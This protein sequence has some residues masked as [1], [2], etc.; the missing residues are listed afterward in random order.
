MPQFHAVLQHAD[1]EARDNVDAGDEYAG[2]RIALSEAGGAVHGAIELRL[3]RQL[4]TALTRRGLVDESGTQIRI[5]G[6]LLSGQSVQG[7][8]RRDFRDTHRAVIDDHVLNRDQYQEDH[9]ADDV[10]AAHHKA[11]EGFDY[12]SGGG[13]AR[14]AIQQDQPRR[15]NVQGQPV[16]RQQ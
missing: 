15:G 4:F 10:V 13:S 14:V 8:A 7:E 6:H 5:D 2:H 3:G 12:M 11:A 1:Q 9:R 16:K